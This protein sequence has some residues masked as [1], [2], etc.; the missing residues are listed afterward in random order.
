MPQA[1]VDRQKL[2]LLGAVPLQQL[3]GGAPQQQRVCHRAPAP[4]AARRGP[5]GLWR[6]LRNFLRRGG[7]PAPAHVPR[8]LRPTRLPGVQRV[9]QVSDHPHW[10]SHPRSSRRTGPPRLESTDSQGKPAGPRDL[11]SG[12]RQNV[13]HHTTYNIV[14]LYSFFIGH[15]ILCKIAS[16]SFK[17][18]R[19]ELMR[20]AHCSIMP[21]KCIKSK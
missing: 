4:L 5:A 14:F 13:G 19:E 2:G 9:E 20:S 1:R 6:R 7:V 8:V 11:K 18:Q 17:T 15:E 12:N 3:L 10:P 21:Q 16:C